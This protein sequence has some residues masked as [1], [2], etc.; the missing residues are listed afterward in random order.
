MF[1]MST[2]AMQKFTALLALFTAAGAL[3]LVVLRS[4]PSARNL[5][6]AVFPYRLWMAAAVALGSTFG[7]LYFSEHVGYEPCKLCWLQRVHMFPLA[8]IL[9]IGAVRR[10]AKVAWYAVP[11]AAIGAAISIWHQLV[12]RYPQLDGDTCS[13]NVPCSVPYFRSFGFVTLSLMALCGFAAIIVLLTIST[14]SQETT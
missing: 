5:V 7:S 13:I 8:L 1:G 3:V 6:A 9:L 2:E 11:I 12:E 4:I 10:D 14:P